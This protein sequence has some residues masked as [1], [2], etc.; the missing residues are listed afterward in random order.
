MKHWTLLTISLFFSLCANGQSALKLSGKSLSQ[1]RAESQE[2]LLPAPVL[3]T[4]KINRVLATAPSYPALRESL[5]ISTPPKAWRYCDLALF[6]KL[7]VQMEKAV[8]FPFKVR[9][10]ETQAVERMEGKLSDGVKQK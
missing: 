3:S 10:G 2:V 5:S 1:L 8:K 6:C 4:N 9:L 7:E